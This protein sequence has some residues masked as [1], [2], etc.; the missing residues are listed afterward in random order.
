[1]HSKS[2]GNT[3][4]NLRERKGCEKEKIGPDDYFPLN[5]F[6]YSSLITV[7]THTHTLL[8]LIDSPVYIWDVKGRCR[9]R[10]EFDPPH[11]HSGPPHTYSDTLRIQWSS[12]YTQWY[13]PYTVILPIYSDTLRIQWSSPYI[14]WY[15]PYIQWFLCVN[16]AKRFNWLAPLLIWPVD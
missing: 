13:S 6:R 3:G 1:M 9:R 15:S 4:R 14:K 2:V 16:G 7:C 8:R 5:V 12:P 10:A 11:I